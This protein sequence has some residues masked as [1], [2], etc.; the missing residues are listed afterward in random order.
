MGEFSRF[1]GL[2]GENVAE[3]FLDLIGWQ[4]ISNIEFDCVKRKKHGCKKH[5]LDFFAAY[6]N[7]LEAEVLDVLMISVK[8]VSSKNIKSDF[9]KY[10]NDLNVTASCFTLSSQYNETVKNHKHKR[11][12]QNLVIFWI[13]ENK[14]IDYSMIKE[15]KSI[16]QEIDTDFELIHVIDN[17]RVNFIYNSIKFTNKLYSNE[18]IEFFYHQ[19]GISEK[20]TGGRQLSGALMPIDYLTSDIVL[21]KINNKKVLVI[22]VNER[23]EKDSFKRIVGLSQN[24]TSGWCQ[25]IILA[26]PDYQLVRHKELRQ[27]V[28]MNFADN[29]FV[30]MVEVKNFSDNFFSLE[31]KDLISEIGSPSHKPLFD[32]ETMLPFGDQIRQLLNRSYINKVDLQNLLRARGVFTRKQIAKEDITPF[33]AKTLLS[34]TEFEFLRRK[35]AAKE[36]S[37]S[38]STAY[39]N[40]DITEDVSTALTI[41]MPVIKHNITKR[42]PNCELLNDLRIESREDGDVSISFEATKYDLNKDW[43]DVSSKQKGEV[44]FGSRIS[45]GIGKTQVASAYSSP[46]MK[47]ITAIVIREVVANLKKMNIMPV[48]DKPVKL[49]S[50][51]FSRTQRNHFL[52]SFLEKLPIKVSLGFRQL[53]SVDFTLDDD[54]EG[55]PEEFIS[56]RNR[57]DESLFTGR[58]LEEIKYLTDKK[59]R[60][61]LIFYAFVAEYHFKYNLNNELVEGKTE[62]EFG[63]L[64]TR[65]KDREFLENMEFEFKIRSIVPFLDR[66]ITQKEHYTLSLLIRTDFDA[67]KLNNAENYINKS[68]QLNIF[69]TNDPRDI[70][71]SV[72]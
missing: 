12:R 17:Y 63:F 52:M 43:T 14:E 62:V 23:F 26:F 42:F 27:A 68:A 7:P 6:M 34:P 36:D 40:S 58:N 13:D 22:C 16:S 53:T 72:D 51:D 49:L 65:N 20:V 70:V 18:K 59:Y 67:I 25:K 64:Y 33:F 30:S 39:L 37:E 55:L 48:E 15:L 2:L 31:A 28:L 46:E 32:I 5:G 3:G 60:D 24:L 50:S 56:L 8:Y 9:K 11:C 38:Y 35:Q 44:T 4:R 29:D 10:I 21:F 1:K 61:A 47:Q 45:E 54:A 41:A 19:T 71:A 66:N 57:V 69:V